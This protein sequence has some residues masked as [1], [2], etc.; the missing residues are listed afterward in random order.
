MRCIYCKSNLVQ[1][2]FG[3]CK[4]CGGQSP[5]HNIEKEVIKRVEEQAHSKMRTVSGI[6]G[7]PKTDLR[8]VEAKRNEVRTQGMVS[9]KAR[10]TTFDDLH[11]TFNV[12]KVIL[13]TLITALIP[14][15]LAI[16]STLIIRGAP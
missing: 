12:N 4:F 10:L 5:D 9:N 1:D 3:R 2:E 8:H 14:M 7:M 11:P 15:M 16:L 6:L 13:A